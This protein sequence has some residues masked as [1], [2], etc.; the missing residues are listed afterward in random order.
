[1]GGGF[2]GICVR[3]GGVSVLGGVW[4]GDGGGGGFR[5]LFWPFIG[6]FIVV[7]A[8]HPLKP[9]PPLPFPLVLRRRFRPPDACY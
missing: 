1:M 3:C 6:C 9:F 7:V 8:P 4:F 2:S 5:G